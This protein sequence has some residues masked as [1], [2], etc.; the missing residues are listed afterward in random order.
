MISSSFWKTCPL[1]PPP[2]FSTAFMDNYVPVPAWICE[3]IEKEL[4]GGGAVWGGGGGSRRLSIVELVKAEGEREGSSLSQ[5]GRCPVTVKGKRVTWQRDRRTNRQRD[6]L[7][8]WE[9]WW[10]QMKKSRINREKIGLSCYFE[11]DHK[12]RLCRVRCVDAY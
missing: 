3:R 1:A 10:W 9:G 8:L 4:V 2:L 5:P 7:G 12:S 6:R 11:P